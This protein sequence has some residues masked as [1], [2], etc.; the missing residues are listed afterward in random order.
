MLGNSTVFS[1]INLLRLFLVYPVSAIANGLFV[2]DLRCF[3][4]VFAFFGSSILLA[5]TNFRECLL[6]DPKEHP[7]LLA[8][9]SSNTQQQRER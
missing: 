6:V 4:L 7:M 9:P 2:T 8:E 3:N 5:S 1:H